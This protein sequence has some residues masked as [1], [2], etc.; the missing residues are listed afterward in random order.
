MSDINNPIRL[1]TKHHRDK[2]IG[3]ILGND[4]SVETIEI[5]P[6]EGNIYI[7]WCDETNKW[8]GSRAGQCIAITNSNGER[9]EFGAS[10]GKDL[11]GTHL[12]SAGSVTTI[13]D[14]SDG[15][16]VRCRE[17]GWQRAEW[18]SADAPYCSNCGVQI[19]RRDYEIRE[20]GDHD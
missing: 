18:A 2:D 8:S 3:H 16:F 9:C 5:R 15:E 13:F 17:C 11:C 14:V 1:S 20:G 7:H 4:R 19:S 6:D 12:R 10:G